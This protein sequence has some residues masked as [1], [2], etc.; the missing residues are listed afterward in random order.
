MPTVKQPGI[1]CWAMVDLPVPDK[2][3]P[4]GGRSIRTIALINHGLVPGEV[5]GKFRGHNTYFFR[6]Y[7][8][9][10][11]KVTIIVGVFWQMSGCRW[12]VIIVRLLLMRGEPPQPI[13]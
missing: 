11:H 9:T 10:H 3:M 7:S 1:Q 2:A 4:T 5:A 13:T 12:E 6:D 8:G